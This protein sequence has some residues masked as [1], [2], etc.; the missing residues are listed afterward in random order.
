MVRI[1]LPCVLLVFLVGC[2]RATLQDR[3]AVRDAHEG[4]QELAKG[5]TMRVLDERFLPVRRV[6]LDDE[7]AP[8]LA[9]PVTLR[10][11]APLTE[12]CDTIQRLFPVHVN[13]VRD[14]AEQKTAHQET[15]H[16][17]KG[18]PDLL[19]LLAEEGFA[20]PPLVRLGI[21]YE[22]AL[23]GLLDQIAAQSGFGWE[24]DRKSNT[25]TFARRMIKTFVLKTV[26]GGVSSGSVVTNK[27]R[28]ERRGGNRE[29]GG[30]VEAEISQSYKG[31]LA[32]DTFK[33]TVANVKT[34]L[35]PQGSVVGNE[36]AGTLSVCDAPDRIRQ[37]GR[38]I[39]AI[40]ESFTRQVAMKVNV[41][42]LD[43]TD[44]SQIGANLAAILP[45]ISVGGGSVGL[46]IGQ[47]SQGLLGSAQ[48]LV[49]DGQLKGSQAMLTAL[50]N[51]GHARQ[52]TSAGIVTLNNQPAPV[53]AIQK[54][55]YLA[56]STTETTDHGTET[57]LSP[58][59]VTTGF[60]MTITP[61]ILKGRTVL[62]QYTVHL[63]SLDAL[64][65]FESQKSRIQLPRVSSRA[66]SQKAT[67]LMGQTLVLEGK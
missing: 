60:S 21:N 17:Q 54:I 67:M 38:Y 64:D 19:A 53:E 32:F 58:G 55:S 34:M 62:L 1:V 29:D 22:G 10:V 11:H 27:S 15:F 51:I 57:S 52:I 59:E 6:P 48:A 45:G 49:L 47:V 23:K 12:L 61:H 42:A 20:Q 44:S 43:V 66:F 36:A 30:Q 26:P 33:D 40:N 31:Q 14:F 24:Y 28:N 41:Y 18:D 37:I 39:D 56:G 46:G 63:S 9:S 35:S 7:H 13:L 65:A 25:I 5:K 3:Q 50:K 16:E 4:F 2:G 8:M